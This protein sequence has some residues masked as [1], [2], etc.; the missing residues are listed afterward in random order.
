MAKP[1]IFLAFA[2]EQ[3]SGDLRALAEELRR[4]RAALKAGADAGLW[5]V[6]ERTDTSLD[7][8]LS[9]FRDPRYKN[10]IAIFHYGGHAGS[11]IL[12]LEGRRGGAEQAH[13]GGLA[14]FLGLQRGLKVVFLNGCSTRAQAEGLLAAGVPAVITTACAIEDTTATEFAT[15]FYTELA[16]GESVSRAFAKAAEAL[17]TGSG[18]PRTTYRSAFVEESG[19]AQDRNV[20]PWDLRYADAAHRIGEWQL[21]TGGVLEAVRARPAV[22]IAVVVGVL[23]VV[24]AIAA[25]VRRPNS[26]NDRGSGGVQTVVAPPPSAP[27]ASAPARARTRDLARSS[28]R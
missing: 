25:M 19:D 18:D 13:A 5:D 26:A 15:G 28:R 9:V 22:A 11:N 21:T 27:A 17:R 8:L 1:V 20:W 2:N 4:V 24:V 16:G 10:R 3:S 23:A 12:Q 6:V 14:S 7:D